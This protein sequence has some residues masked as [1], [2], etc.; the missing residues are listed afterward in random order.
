M[1]TL[2]GIAFIILGL[3]IAVGINLFHLIIPAILIYFGFKLI[4]RDRDERCRIHNHRY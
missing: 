2:S 1:K 3:T 4:V